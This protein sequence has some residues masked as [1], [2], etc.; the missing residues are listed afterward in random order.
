M[1]AKQLRAAFERGAR[2][3]VQ[4]KEDFDRGN[5]WQTENGAPDDDE[6]IEEGRY[7]WRIHPKDAHLIND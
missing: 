3:Q 6:E 5:D 4:I 2:L 7:N 1:N